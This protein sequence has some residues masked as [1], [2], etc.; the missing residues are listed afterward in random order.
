MYF[1][2]CQKFFNLFKIKIVYNFVIFYNTHN[3]RSWYT[4][5]TYYTYIIQQSRSQSNS[6][7][8][9]IIN[10][11]NY[12]QAIIQVQHKVYYIKFFV[13][14]EKGRVR[15]RSK[16]VTINIVTTRVQL[17]I[18]ITY[19]ILQGVISHSH[20]PIPT[21]SKYSYALHNMYNTQ[22]IR[23]NRMG[24]KPHSCVWVK[25]IHNIPFAMLRKKKLL[26]T[27]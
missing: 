11:K 19:Y 2:Q 26:L 24:A 27:L 1:V 3:D 17:I 18:H 23:S 8:D 15:F 13:W 16:T 14:A 9:Q 6:T 25:I 4:G 7:T 22:V 20:A 12:I 21:Q 10:D 5:S